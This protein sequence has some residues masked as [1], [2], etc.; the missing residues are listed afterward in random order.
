MCG[1]SGGEESQR[2]WD[3]AHTEIV[4]EEPP[5]SE[6][7]CFKRLP[8]L[9]PSVPPP[10]SRVPHS[11]SSSQSLTLPHRPHQP[12]V[13]ISGLVSARAHPVTPSKPLTGGTAFQHSTYLGQICLVLGSI[14]AANKWPSM[15]FLAALS[16][17]G[18]T[19]THL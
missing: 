13:L 17:L 4:L 18:G 2:D 7:S 9:L 5:P 11:Y 12:S 6:P 19:P 3:C 16:N 1:M 15:P 10:Q 8:R 14:R